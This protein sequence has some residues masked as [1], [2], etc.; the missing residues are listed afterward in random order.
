MLFHEMS[1]FFQV[2]CKKLLKTSKRDS[3]L[4]KLS[5]FAKLAIFQLF[6]RN[7][8]LSAT[9]FRKVREKLET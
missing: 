7:E 4:E 5:N 1:L 6:S 3:F 8:P 2:S 9:F